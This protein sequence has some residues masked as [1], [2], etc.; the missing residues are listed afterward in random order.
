M[1]AQ[2]AKDKIK[3]IL[4][5]VLDSKLTVLENKQIM[6]M[7]FLDSVHKYLYDFKLTIDSLGD[8]INQEEIKVFEPVNRN[9]STPNT[10]DFTE[11]S[12]KSSKTVANLKTTKINDKIDK[13]VPRKF[14][15]L[16]VIDEE[17]ANNRSNYFVLYL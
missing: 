9:T 17:E 8:K 7:G 4:S 16:I 1:K 5:S 3:N 6:D 11:R 2:I 15:Q 12:L 10:P 14:T 13:S